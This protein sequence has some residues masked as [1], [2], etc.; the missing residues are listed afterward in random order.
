MILLMLLEHYIRRFA[1]EN[2]VQPVRL[3]E[4]ALKGVACVCMA[5][6]YS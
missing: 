3:S 4:G 6:Q 2:G 5:G 1:D